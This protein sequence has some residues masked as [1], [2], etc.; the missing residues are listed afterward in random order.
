LP[1][2]VVHLDAL[3]RARLDEAGWLGLVRRSLGLTTFGANTCTANAVREPTPHG[4]G[5]QCG[6]RVE[7][8]RREE[9]V[10]RAPQ[11]QSVGAPLARGARTGC[12]RDA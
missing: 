4:G 8:R 12:V 6:G 10:A 3:E 9:A 2:A 1:Y 5:S 11:T 7:S